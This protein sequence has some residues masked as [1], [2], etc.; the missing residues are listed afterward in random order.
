MSNEATKSALRIKVSPEG[1]EGVWLADRDSLAEWI[2]GQEFESIHN[3]G[4][5]GAMAIGADHDPESVLDDI[6][7]ADRVA[8][9]TG[10]SQRGNMGHAL[11]LIMPEGHNELPERLEMYDIGP[12][13]EHDLEITGG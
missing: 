12:I 6:M 8:V 11:A 1:R 4:A 3:F 5:I 13:T 9:L 7:K 2:A 10:D